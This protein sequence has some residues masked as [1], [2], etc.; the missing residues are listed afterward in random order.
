MTYADASAYAAE[1]PFGLC[2]FHQYVG[3]GSLCNHI[4]S[5][6]KLKMGFIYTHIFV[7]L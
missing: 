1:D 2:D 7:E 6:Q 3:S 4:W 5:Y